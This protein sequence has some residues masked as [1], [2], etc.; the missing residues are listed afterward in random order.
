[1]NFDTIE[2]VTEKFD[3]TYFQTILVNKTSLSTGD[4]IKT[5]TVQNA[6]TICEE[7]QNIYNELSEKL[8]ALKISASSMRD[9]YNSVNPE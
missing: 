1:M 8:D 3:D 6:D 7:L 9:I 5:D 2:G 4:V